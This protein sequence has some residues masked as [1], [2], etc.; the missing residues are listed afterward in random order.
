MCSQ[1]SLFYS[2][3][4]SPFSA[5]TFERGTDAVATVEASAKLNGTSAIFDKEKIPATM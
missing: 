3:F 5:P 1:Q 4:A 2:I